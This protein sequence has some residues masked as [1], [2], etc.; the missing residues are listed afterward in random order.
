[1]LWLLRNVRVPEVEHDHER[2][3][4]LV[5]RMLG[6][7]RAVAARVELGRGGPARLGWPP[8]FFCVFLSL[9]YFLFFLNSFI[10]FVLSVQKCLNK[11]VIVFKNILIKI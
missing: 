7:C 10:T 5:G 3:L 6:C 1:M 9:F 8:P 2:S 4:D 11:F